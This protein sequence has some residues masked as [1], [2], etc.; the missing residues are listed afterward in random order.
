MVTS[1]VAGIYQERELGGL[2]SNQSGKGLE[3]V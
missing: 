2:Y 1:L 3:D